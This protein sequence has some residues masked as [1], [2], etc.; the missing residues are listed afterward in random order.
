ML[1]V[2]DSLCHS[3]ADM[4]ASKPPQKVVFVWVTCSTEDFQLMN[5][6]LQAKS[7]YSFARLCLTLQQGLT[8]IAVFCCTSYAR[9]RS[10]VLT[11]D[12]PSCLAFSS[13]LYMTLSLRICFAIH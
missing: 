2:L 4:S 7:R 3:H 11:R 8:L 10:E 5:Q 12:R 13:T 9:C 6:W 1:G